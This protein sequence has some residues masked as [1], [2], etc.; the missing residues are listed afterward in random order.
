M[1]DR[2]T[3]FI[4][5]LLALIVVYGLF[6]GKAEPISPITRPLTIE[7][8]GNGYFAF[9]QWLASEGVSTYSLRGRF[10]SLGGSS[11]VASA[12]GNILVTTLPY[13][14][15]LRES[16]ADLLIRPIGCWPPPPVSFLTI[17]KQSPASVFTP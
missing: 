8:G 13:V 2:L 9:Q 14:R 16:E 3:T 5:A 12:A 10:S 4:G 6:F 7:R 17:L 15:P 11:G 1:R